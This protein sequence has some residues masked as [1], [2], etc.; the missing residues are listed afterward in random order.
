LLNTDKL[1]I[2]TEQIHQ[3]A[4]LVSIEASWNYPAILA[5]ALTRHHNLLALRHCHKLIVSFVEVLHLFKLGFN[6][7]ESILQPSLRFNQLYRFLFTDL[8]QK[9]SE[10]YLEVVIVAGYYIKRSITK[11]LMY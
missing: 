8:M 9:L 7:F 2:K 3:L 1:I 5:E 11:E 10:L 6:D 4:I